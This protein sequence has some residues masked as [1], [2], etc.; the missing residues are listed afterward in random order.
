MKAG[1]SSTL[2]QQIR[3]MVQS[4]NHSHVSDSDLLRLFV[5]KHDEEAFAVL[6]RR[7]GPMV[8]SVARRHL[9]RSGDSDDVIQATFLLLVQKARGIATGESLGSW[10]HGVALRLAYALRQ[11][12]QE[13]SKHE[14]KAAAQGLTMNTVANQRELRAVL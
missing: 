9:D 11:Q 2:V 7:H 8:L 6:M 10:L 3:R 14:T 1:T 13:R 12:N 5:D 4:G